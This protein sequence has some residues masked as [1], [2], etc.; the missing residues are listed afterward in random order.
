M[1]KHVARVRLAVALALLGGA[2]CASPPRPLSVGMRE[3]PTDVVLGAQRRAATPVPLPPFLLP[4]PRDFLTL[5][6]NLGSAPR[7]PLGPCPEED[8]FK[9]PKQSAGNSVRLPP[10]AASYVFRTAG[11]VELTGA[12]ARKDTFSV[13]STRQVKNVKRAS[14]GSF[15]FDVVAS[16]GDEATTTSFSSVAASSLPPVPSQVPVPPGAVQDGNGMFITKIVA[17]EASFTPDPPMLVLPYPVEPQLSWTVASRDVA[18][19]VVMAYVGTLGKRSRVNACGLPIDAQTVHL[20]GEMTFCPPPLPLSTDIPG[21]LRPPPPSETIGVPDPIVVP[22]A[23]PAPTVDPIPLPVPSPVDPVDNPIDAY[24]T[25]PPPPPPP[26]PPTLPCAEVNPGG[27]GV[28]TQ[29]LSQTT[30]SFTADYAF[31]PQYGGLIIQDTVRSA[32]TESGQ[33]VTRFLTSTINS[34]PVAPK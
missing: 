23:P 27:Q 11:T 4:V 30:L 16:F 18:T 6:P 20:N 17:G 7:L 21:Y 28:H 12:N 26:K 5:I 34:E 31:A 33:G 10:A 13:S 25:L 14:D 15:T 19:G 8:P 2:A 29:P 1:T 24:P 32:G 3:F 9:F 22:E